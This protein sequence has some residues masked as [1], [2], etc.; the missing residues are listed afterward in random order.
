MTIRNG[1]IICELQR[2]LLLLMKNWFTNFN[3]Q[4]TLN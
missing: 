4:K 2:L 3:A 1:L